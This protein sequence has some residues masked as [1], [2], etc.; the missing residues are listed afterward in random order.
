MNTLDDLRETLGRHAEDV[1]GP[2]DVARSAAVHHRVAVVRRRR[3]AV[4]T[5]VLAAAVIAG[6]AVVAWPRSDP[7]AAPAGPVVLGERAP[8]S[9][10]SLGYAF[11]ATGSSQV[12]HGTGRIRFA[13][14]D[15]PR[16]ISWT[17]HGTRQA[18]F[19]MPGPEEHTTSVTHFRDFLFV[20][21]GETGPILVG[22]RGGTVG[23]ATYALSSRVTPA[24]YTRDGVT[25]RRSVGGTQLLAARIAD[26]TTDLSTTYT[27]PGGPVDIK[28]MCTRLPQGY[29][30]NV[31]LNGHG[32]VSSGGSCD[33]DAT[34]DPGAGGYTEFDQVKPGRTMVVR[35]WISRSMRDQTPVPPA[36]LPHV[37]LGIGVYGPVDLVHVGGYAVPRTIEA[38]GHTWTTAD[39]DQGSSG[40]TLRLGAAGRD[41]MAMV[42][43]HSITR[44]VVSFSAGRDMG[45][46][47]E[48]MAHGRGALN[49][50][51]VPAGSPVRVRMTTGEGTFGVVLYERVD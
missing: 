26:G 16:L 50:L 36:D 12:I 5:G 4:G 20:P 23:V 6:S 35:A 46:R 43:W 49:D 33:A 31:S 7:D 14:S 37:R 39:V 3:R 44:S 22:A 18:R 1:A 27:T 9:F 42:P 8:G 15:T 40:R 45:S 21:A 47:G 38:E 41:R 11:D 19:T 28:T 48:T 51:W 24:G 13:A 25:Y 32:F 10:R 17:L 34:F 2:T 30:V 29:A